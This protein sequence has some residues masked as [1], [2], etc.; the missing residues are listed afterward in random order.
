MAR[1]TSPFQH[2]P[3][4]LAP[5]T[6]KARVQVL[7][8]AFADV[9]KD[10]ELLAEAKKANFAIDYVSAEELE[11]LFKVSTRSIRRLPRK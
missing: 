2:V 8:K 3:Y 10:P 11:R 9:L 7:R 5:G 4:F 6:P 1:M